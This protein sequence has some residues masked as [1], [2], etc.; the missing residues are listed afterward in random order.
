M[1]LIVHY[2]RNHF[3]SDFNWRLALPEDLC[4]YTS[5][6]FFDV[7][8]DTN[9]KMLLGGVTAPSNSICLVVIA[10]S[11]MPSFRSE[12][13]PEAVSNSPRRYKVTISSYTGGPRAP[14]AILVARRQNL[15][16]AHDLP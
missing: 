5:D 13:T 3:I 15:A 4:Y 6:N 11:T 16:V 1:S 9:Q 2:A 8:F 7:H 12:N 14:W 10:V